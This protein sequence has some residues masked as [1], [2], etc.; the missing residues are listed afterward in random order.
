M[1]QPALH[2]MPRARAPND[3]MAA[4]PHYFKDA[5]QPW[6]RPAAPWSGNPAWLRPPIQWQLANLGTPLVAPQLTPQALSQIATIQT[7]PLRPLDAVPIANVE[8]QP[9]NKSNKCFKLKRLWNRQH[10]DELNPY[11][12]EWA[13]VA[14]VEEELRNRRPRRRAMP[15]VRSP[16]AEVMIARERWISTLHP[17]QQRRARA[18][19]AMQNRQHLLNT[20]QLVPPVITLSPS[21]PPPTAV[22]ASPTPPPPPPPSPARTPAPVKKLRPILP[23][24]TIPT[25]VQTWDA[26][27]RGGITQLLDGTPD[28]VVQKRQGREGPVLERWTSDPSLKMKD[29]DWDELAF[30]R[31]SKAARHAQVAVDMHF[32]KQKAEDD[33]PSP[34]WRPW[35]ARLPVEQSDHKKVVQAPSLVK[36][37]NS[38]KTRKGGRALAKIRKQKRVEPLIV[39]NR[40]KVMPKNQFLQFL[41]VTGEK[42][43]EAKTVSH[44]ENAQGD[45]DDEDEIGFGKLVIDESADLSPQHP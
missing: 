24:P 16:W 5:R 10:V 38:K 39:V 30:D 28:S 36:H 45:K 3:S 35:R 26:D 18:L 33:D 7:V 25:I 9:Q 31:Q 17:S 40:Q 42:R 23:K 27:L 20:P 34:H 11:L 41:A 2:R 12:P 14:L 37:R 43:L 32:Q 8:R 21:P 6:L 1:T 29:R 19:I 13:R 15:A 4:G 44:G 22:T